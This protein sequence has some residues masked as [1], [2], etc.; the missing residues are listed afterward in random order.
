MEIHA[1]VAHCDAY[2]DAASCQ[3][4]GPNG[5]QVEG[6]REVRRIATGVSACVE[7]FERAR[8]L[9]ADAV[10]VHH[11]LIFK[12]TPAEPLTGFRARRLRI[13]FESGIHL[14]AYHLPLDRHPEIGNNALAAKALGLYQVEPFGLH[15][16]Q[17]VGCHGRYPVPVPASEL[18]RRCAA[19]FGQEP[20]AILAGPDP[21]ASV[22]LISGGAQRE[23][24]QAIAAGFDAY[25]TGEAAEWVTNVARDAGIHYLACGHHA[26]ERLGIR[27]LGEHLAE[28]FEL[29]HHFV[30]VPNPV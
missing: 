8:D 15:E 2:L 3:D 26:T 25:L 6:T 1:L 11:G 14:V 10:F 17:T 5:L 27:A 19:T 16:G 13:L 28:R 9:G 21:V 23:L 30:D 4:Y 22:G 20:L 29:E 24:Y 12:F 18:V 7:L